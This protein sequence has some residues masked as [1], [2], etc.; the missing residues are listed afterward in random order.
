MTQYDQRYQQVEQQYNAGRDINIVAPLSL[1]EAQQRRNRSRMLA[2]VRSLIGELEQPLYGADFIELGLQEQRDA[3]ANPWGQDLQELHRPAHP[4]PSSTSIV[5]IYDHASGEL[6]ILGEP[7]S[8]KTTL[9]LKLTRDLLSRATQD[10]MYPVPS[11][12]QPLVMGSETAASC[13][14]ACWRIE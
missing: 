13:R 14:L 6:L 9:L 5:Q 2:K 7:G 1:T 12:I 10:E 8:G 4:L 3:V 11:R